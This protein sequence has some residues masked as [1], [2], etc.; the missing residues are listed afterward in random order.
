[1]QIARMYMYVYWYVRVFVCVCMCRQLG[2][3]YDARYQKTGGK[4]T[5][6]TPKNNLSHSK[7]QP[8]AP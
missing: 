1:M 7:K 3:V 5:F 2:Q 8:L 6:R 4:I